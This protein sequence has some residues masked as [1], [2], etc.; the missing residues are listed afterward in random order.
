FKDFVRNIE[1][2]SRLIEVNS[3]YFVYPDKGDM[4][5]FSVSANIYSR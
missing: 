3:I 4:F 1:K 5:D 2:L